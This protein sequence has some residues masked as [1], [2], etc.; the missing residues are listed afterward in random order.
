MI[1]TATPPASTIA[2]EETYEDVRELIHKLTYRHINRYGGDFDE[3]LSDAHLG[4]AEAYDRF[5]SRRGAQFITYCYWYVRGYLLNG[6]NR[7]VGGSVKKTRFE[8]SIQCDTEALGELM[9][10]THFDLGQ[11]AEKLSVDAQAAIR[12]ALDLPRVQTP[13]KLKRGLLQYLQRNFGWTAARCVETFT[14]I[15]RVLG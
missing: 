4:F 3:A 14:E 11:L 12:L 1:T 9:G 5:D 2:I 13:S 10:T 8:R 15:R 6:Y 7:P